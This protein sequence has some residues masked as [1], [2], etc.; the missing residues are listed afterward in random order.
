MKI[1]SH[2]SIEIT[3]D[4]FVEAADH[5]RKLESMLSFVRESYPEA[6]LIMRGRRKS[7]AIPLMHRASTGHAG[8]PSRYGEE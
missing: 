4:D 8:A 1:S 6:T 7:K 3:V 2:I 5:Q